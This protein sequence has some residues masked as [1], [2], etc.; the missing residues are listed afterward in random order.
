MVRAEAPELRLAHQWLD[1][2]SGIGLMATGM[3]R[4]GWDLQLTEYG[5]GNWRATFLLHRSR[6]LHRRR[7][8]V[9]A[10]AVA[11]GAAGGVGGGAP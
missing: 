1:S 8:G 10:N 11:G 5:D 7:L 6:P 9:G 2:W 4:Q 3:E